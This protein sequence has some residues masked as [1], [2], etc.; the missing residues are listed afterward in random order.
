MA[1]PTLLQQVSVPQITLERESHVGNLNGVLGPFDSLVISC[2]VQAELTRQTGFG[3]GTFDQQTPPPP[4][5]DFI[6]P[7]NEASD[8]DKKSLQ[9]N[10]LLHYSKIPFTSLFAEGRFE[11]QNIGQSD[12]F[13][14]S[15]DILNKA[16]FSQHTAFSSQSS[17]LRFGFNTS[18]WRKVDFSAHY[19]RYEDDSQYDS[20]PLV[21]PVQTAYPTFIRSRE[22][23]LDEVETK[24]VLHLTPSLKTSLS[25]QYQATDYGLNTSPYISFGNVISPGGQLL[26]GQDRSHIISINATMTPMPRLYFFTTFSYRTSTTTTAANGSP[27]VV[28]YRGDIYTAFASGTCILNRTTDLFGSYAFSEANYGQ[29]DFASGLPLGIQYLRHSVQVG[30]ARRFSRNISAK[31]QYRFD[32]YDEPSSWGANNYRAHSVFGVFTFQF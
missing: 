18:P 13:A 1:E 9:E 29:N 2:G 11:Q 7:F 28:P 6:V 17:D 12:Q 22:L 30:L 8:Y 10:L 4:F 3:T 19:R 26:A 24:L 14:A 31:L 20:D 32:Y 15:Q 5:T 23:T 25:Y 16:V 27:A 21:E